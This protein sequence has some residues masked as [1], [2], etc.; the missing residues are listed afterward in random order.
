MIFSCKTSKN[1]S[2]NRLLVTEDKIPSWIR[3]SDDIPVITHPRNLKMSFTVDTLLF[4]RNASCE[5]VRTGSEEEQQSLF[6]INYEPE[7]KSIFVPL[8]SPL[9]GLY[10][11]R[12]K[13]STG[14]EDIILPFLYLSLEDCKREFLRKILTE[15][16]AFPLFFP[17][18][19]NLVP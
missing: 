9:P 8:K 2:V 11:I 10:E 17:E 14:R 7:D 12:I 1:L 16:R 19:R 6:Q 13:G 5:V 15:Q 4:W 18:Y 3:C